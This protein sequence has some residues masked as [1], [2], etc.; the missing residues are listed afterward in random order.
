MCRLLLKCY[1]DFF[2]Y[3]KMTPNENRNAARKNHRKRGGE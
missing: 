3:T 1:G 2:R